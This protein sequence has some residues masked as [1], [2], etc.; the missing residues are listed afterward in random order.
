MNILH[1]LVALRRNVSAPEISI[2][3]RS[4]ESRNS[5]AHHVDIVRARIFRTLC[6]R[7]SATVGFDR[8]NDFAFIFRPGTRPPETDRCA[9]ARAHTV[10]VLPLASSRF[11]LHLARP[12]ALLVTGRLSIILSTPLRNLSSTQWS[13]FPASLLPAPIGRPPRRA[14]RPAGRAQRAPFRCF[15][16]FRPFFS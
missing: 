1:K 4:S 12:F 13:L 9:R 16:F 5:N 7:H 14:G 11:N 6:E 15:I 3:L 2:G 8:S 10:G